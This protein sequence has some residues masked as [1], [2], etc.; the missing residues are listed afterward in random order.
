MFVRFPAKMPSV[1]VDLSSLP[2]S[3]DLPSNSTIL[4]SLFAA[5]TFLV[6]I[7]VIYVVVRAYIL[8]VK[9]R[10]G[11]KQKSAL[12]V[13][14]EQGG[15][16]S[17]SALPSSKS[18]PNS[19]ER[20]S[21]SASALEQ[22]ARAPKVVQGKWNIG[23]FN[24]FRWDNLQLTLPV[25]LTMPG[26]DNV[27]SRGVGM[28]IGVTAPPVN[29]S[30]PPRSSDEKTQQQ[31]QQQPSQTWQQGRRA[32]P[33][34]ESPLPALYQT[35]VPASMAKII[36]SRHKAISKTTSTAIVNTLSSDITSPTICCVRLTL[37]WSRPEQFN[38]A[39]AYY[40]YLPF[41]SPTPYPTILHRKVI[42]LP[43]QP[44][45]RCHARIT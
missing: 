7:H 37:T 14:Q 11:Q 9:Q 1:V 2:S 21:V 16:S 31:G 43:Y 4:L 12:L 8:R 41:P 20:S 3:F 23:L 5:L 39:R 22:Q 13:A 18:Q 36:M 15:S 34:F 38:A 32:G 44:L 33:A 24:W 19:V 40:Y 27:K 6:L 35:D 28:G 30:A 10:F 25:T 17:S 26:S 29:L 45:P 42:N